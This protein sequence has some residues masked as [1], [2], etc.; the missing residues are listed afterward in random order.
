MITFI[1][2]ILLLIVGYFTYGKFVERVFVAD[3]K[4]QTPLSACAIT[5]TTCR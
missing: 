5:S 1:L 3:R 4:R 2:S